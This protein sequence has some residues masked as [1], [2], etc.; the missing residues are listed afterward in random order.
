MTSGMNV[1]PEGGESGQMTEV[2]QRDEYRSNPAIQR[3]E[4]PAVGKQLAASE[5]LAASPVP[6]LSRAKRGIISEGL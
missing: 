6:G 4:P 5:Q 2:T 3:Q 1:C